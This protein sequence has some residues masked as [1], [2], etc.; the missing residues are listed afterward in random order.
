MPSVF[1]Q[2]QCHLVFRTDSRFV[3]A[4]ELVSPQP[5]YSLV[6]PLYP[7]TL[8]VESSPGPRTCFLGSSPSSF[9]LALCGGPRRMCTS[10]QN[11][12]I[13]LWWG[14]GKTKTRC[15][16]KSKKTGK[17]TVRNPEYSLSLQR[18]AA[19]D[20]SQPEVVSRQKTRIRAW[21][22]GTDWRSWCQCIAVLLG[23]LLCF[24]FCLVTLNF[25]QSAQRFLFTFKSFSFA[26][27]AV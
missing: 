6:A 21:L 13:C 18:F 2:L 3:L 27:W 22:L 20:L 24:L 9:P 8:T 12:N 4:L 11:P 7:S 14:G 19:Q 23:R 17:P 16:E 26:V 1:L 10:I 15:L 25:P 5:P